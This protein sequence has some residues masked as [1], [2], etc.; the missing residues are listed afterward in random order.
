MLAKTAAKSTKTRTLSKIPA[1]SFARTQMRKKNYMEAIKLYKIY[2]KKK[3]KSREVWTEL[4]VAY[5]KVG[6]PK[7]ALRHLKAVQGK[8]NRPSFNYYY[9][10]LAHDQLGQYSKAGRYF[11]RAATGT[12]WYAGEA[13]FVLGTNAYNRKRAKTASQWLR[14]VVQRKSDHPRAKRAGSLLAK[15]QST[16]PRSWQPI[17]VVKHPDRD[18]ALYRF[19]KLSLFPKPHFWA[20]QSG[21]N[22]RVD[23]I[24]EPQESNGATNQAVDEEALTIN[25]IFGLGPIRR[26]NA[27][28][29][30]G[31]NYLQSFF[32]NRERFAEWTDDVFDLSYLPFRFDLL[33][34]R[35]QL[36]IDARLEIKPKF[37][38]GLFSR[39]EFRRRGSSFL[40]SNED[41]ELRK[42]FN[43]S[44]T[45]LG[46]PWAGYQWDDNARSLFYFYLRTELI[47]AQEEFS[48]RTYNLKDN[49][50]SFVDK[51]SFG[52]THTHEL[53]QINTSINAELFHYAFSH[54]D[55]FLDYG[56]RGLIAGGQY[57]L[58]KKISLSMH[59]G[60]YR[61]NYFLD[62]PKAGDCS[63]NIEGVPNNNPVQSTDNTCS[64]DDTGFLVQGGLQWNISNT[65]RVDFFPSFVR[66]GSG[67][68]EYDSSTFQ[69][70]A[71]YTIAFPSVERVTSFSERFSDNAFT[72]RFQF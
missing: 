71:L 24:V 39:L 14:F 44:K 68:N 1:L 61:D 64:R 19:H 57:D 37:F 9:Q 62:I 11:T 13:A 10:G 49:D 48:N 59:L 32:T 3:S 12:D 28:G 6:L 66:N 33:D 34:R 27:Y 31:Y 42:S 8:L 20:F 29:W 5:Y 17:Q 38:L 55:P 36:Y 41:P 23:S 63:R 2:L 18:L 53:P 69:I 46:I 65:Q 52:L 30:V 22:F 16:P 54:N 45:A 15:I 4:G 58:N 56:R 40:G 35:H 25:G 70:K 72:K 43:I 47:E 50:V 67:L 60:F 7:K 26:G 51:F 21:F